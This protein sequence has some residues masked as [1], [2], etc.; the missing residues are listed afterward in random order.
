MQ[1]IYRGT[2]ETKRHSDWWDTFVKRRR[3]DAENQTNT[4]ASASVEGTG[5]KTSSTSQWKHE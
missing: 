2:D 4:G 5:G 1:Y 3:R